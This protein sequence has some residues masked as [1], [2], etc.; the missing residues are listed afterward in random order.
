MT[1]QHQLLLL[2]PI[3]RLMLPRNVATVSLSFEVYGGLNVVGAT[4]DTHISLYACTLVQKAEEEYG[5]KLE[6]I[7]RAAAEVIAHEFRHTQQNLNKQLPI[8]GYD[9]DAFPFGFTGHSEEQK[10]Y[11]DDLAEQD[12]RRF[13][14]QALT[15][16]D[17]AYFRFVGRLF[18]WVAVQQYNDWWPFILNRYGEIRDE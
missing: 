14:T 18:H 2:E 16:L 17:S 1:R 7:G 12:A 15:R 10:A 13:A 8:V 11:W 9:S 6:E 4:R 3:Y 5:T